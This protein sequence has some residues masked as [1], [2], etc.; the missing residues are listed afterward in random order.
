MAI[1]HNKSVKKRISEEYLSLSLDV[2]KEDTWVLDTRNMNLLGPFKNVVEGREMQSNL[3][4][5]LRE[6]GITTDPFMLY[7]FN[8]T[9][10]DKDH[11]AFGS[12]D[13]DAETD[14]KRGL[15]R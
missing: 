12:Y 3:H 4:K 10:I 5:M 15:D 8:G 11:P 6:N 13:M 1:Q 2:R 9:V 7:T 14:F